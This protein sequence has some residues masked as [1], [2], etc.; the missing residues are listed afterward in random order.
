MWALLLII[1]VYFLITNTA[2]ADYM[3]PS[4]WQQMQFSPNKAVKAVIKSMEVDRDS[5][6]IEVAAVGSS[7]TAKITLCSDES[8]T[9]FATQRQTEPVRAVYTQ[10]RMNIVR[11]ALKTGEPVEL[12]F[13]GP[14]SP[15]LNSI[16]ISKGA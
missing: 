10:E 14:W 11:E 6:R 5:V 12:G 8:Q 9:P 13:S 1:G 4:V 3:N 2:N 7:E 15:C 16:R